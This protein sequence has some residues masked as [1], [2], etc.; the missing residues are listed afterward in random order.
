MQVRDRAERQPFFL[1]AIVQLLR[2]AGDPDWRHYA[3]ASRSFEKGVPLGVNFRLPRTPALF[4][5]KLRH[6]Q[7]KEADADLDGGLRD[8]YA[9]TKG[10]EEQ[11]AKQFEKEVALGAMVEMGLEEARL[12]FGEDLT[13]ASIGAIPKPDSTVRVVHDGTHGQHVDDKIRVRD[14]QRCPTGSDLQL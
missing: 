7:Y 5:R 11:I 1:R 6:R 3:E 14:A 2:L 12:E 4:T 8:N 13:T 10:H 9:S